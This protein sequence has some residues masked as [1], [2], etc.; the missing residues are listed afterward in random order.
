MAEVAAAV[1]AE[2][3]IMV[4]RMEDKTIPVDQ[5]GGLIKNIRKS[6]LIKPIIETLYPNRETLS[7]S[8]SNPNLDNFLYSRHKTPF[9]QFNSYSNHYYWF[10][11]IHSFSH[12][13]IQK[14]FS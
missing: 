13:K 6:P 2:A 5:I 9:H 3:V 8:P 14:I 11:Y 10:K 12:Q 7:L 1:A 4:D